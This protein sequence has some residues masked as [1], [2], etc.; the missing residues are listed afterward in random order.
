[1][2]QA[3]ELTPS[4]FSRKRFFRKLKQ[5]FS[6][7]GYEVIEKAL[8][9]YYAAQRPET[10]AWA[11]TTVYSALV[12]FVMPMDISPDFIPVSGYVDDLSVLLAAVSTIAAYIDERVKDKASTQLAKLGFSRR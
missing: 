7:A 2:S 8:W 12:Y 1:M 9:L 6:T 11:K 10:P 3:R 5:V 4:V